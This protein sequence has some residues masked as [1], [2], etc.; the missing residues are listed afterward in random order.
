MKSTSCGPCY[1]A[2]EV[3]KPT[4]SRTFRLALCN[5]GSMERR[6]HQKLTED[7]KAVGAGMIRPCAVDLDFQLDLFVILFVEYFIYF[8]KN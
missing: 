4:S 8:R 1:D 6:S 5:W 7:E 3:D 2:F